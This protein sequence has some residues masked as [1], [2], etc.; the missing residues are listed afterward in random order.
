MDEVNDKGVEEFAKQ[1]LDLFGARRGL[2]KGTMDLTQLAAKC[3]VFVDD[4]VDDFRVILNPLH[5]YS[6]CG[7]RLDPA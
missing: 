1:T 6:P 7:I 2:R 5:D 4:L 3:A